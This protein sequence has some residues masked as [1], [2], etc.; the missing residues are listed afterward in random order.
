MIDSA[1]SGG[2]LLPYV[3]FG[4]FAGAQYPVARKGMLSVILNKE[5][6]ESAHLNYRVPCM[7]PLQRLSFSS[8]RRRSSIL[9]LLMPSSIPLE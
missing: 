5:W 4:G 3:W 1:L 2:G 8:I 6:A 7:L 9:T